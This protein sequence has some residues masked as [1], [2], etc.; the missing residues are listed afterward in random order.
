MVSNNNFAL[1]W[2]Q[3]FLQIKI[4][5]VFEKILEVEVIYFL[6]QDVDGVPILSKNSL[7]DII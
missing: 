2:C 5:F 4:T 1:W 7:F 6:P 3:W